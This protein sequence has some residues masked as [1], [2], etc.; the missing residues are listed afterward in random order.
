[1]SQQVARLW[2]AFHNP[3]RERGSSIEIRTRSS[4]PRD[5]SAANPSAQW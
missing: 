2:L 3:K 4:P 5:A 1:L